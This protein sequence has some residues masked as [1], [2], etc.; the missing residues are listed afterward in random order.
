MPR[1]RL[2]RRWR[3]SAGTRRRPRSRQEARQG[4]GPRPPGRRPR[5]RRKPFGRSPGTSRNRKPSLSGQRRPAGPPPPSAVSLLGVV[6]ACCKEV[7]GIEELLLRL[8]GIFPG[9]DFSRSARRAAAPRGHL[10]LT[11]SASAT[12]DDAKRTQ[13]FAEGTAGRW[14]RRTWRQPAANRSRHPPGAYGRPLER[15]ACSSAS[16]PSPGN[17]YPR[18]RQGTPQG[19]LHGGMAVLP[20]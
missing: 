4:A 1:P 2:Q 14:M 11:R 10:T 12:S 16:A 20:H 15:R 3:S 9:A 13:A 18:P 6:L 7:H 5:G 19:P 8:P 17:R